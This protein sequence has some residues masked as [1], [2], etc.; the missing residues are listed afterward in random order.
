VDTVA[1]IAERKNL[2]CALFWMLAMAAY[3]H[4]A[5]KP[6]PQRFAL[7]FVCMAVG[8]MA[9]PVLVTLPCV[10]LL[11][12]FWPLRRFNLSRGREKAAAKAP[13]PAF[14]SSSPSRLVLEKLP[15]FA[16]SLASGVI[17]LL[18]HESLGLEEVR[19]GLPLRLRIENAFVSYVRY[20]GKALWPDDL[21]VLYF[22][23]G[24]WPGGRAGLSVLAVLLVSGFA[25]W[26]LRRRPW[27]FVGWFWFL[28]VL[29]PTIGLRQVGV[30]SMADRF[31][32]LP[33]IGL[34]IAVVW[35]AADLT[36][37]WRH[38]RAILAV[39]AGVVL[40]GLGACTF[41]Q[42]HHWQNSVALFQ[43][44]VALDPNNFVARGNL[45]AAYA[46]AGQ[47][48]ESREQAEEAIRTNPAFV[49]ARLQLG[50]LAVKERKF[51]DARM[52]YRN[53]LQTRPA[54]LPS[55]RRIGEDLALSQQ[56]SDAANQYA[57]YL[58]LAPDDLAARG[59]RAVALSLAHRPA[60]AI[61]EYE[62]ILREKPD[63]T[64]I[65]NNLAWLRATHSQTEARNGVEAVRL[66]ERACELSR[67]QQPVY[68]GTLA[69]AYA[70]A[71]RFADAINAAQEAR[72]LALAI[73]Q[74]EVAKANENLLTFY[75]ANKPYRDEKP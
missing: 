70:E 9:K 52:H 35:S 13:A 17:T 65:L 10:L 68:L 53:A 47:L 50:L 19:Y 41:L 55:I 24:Q 39:S 44:V 67:R 2:L 4:H 51:N 57:L 66:A 72:D 1:W 64:E 74:P 61:V 23:P 69:A 30:Q 15:L 45:S 14:S 49:E 18:A 75:R 73:G 46:A 62:A 8:L 59:A 26:Q 31:A 40:A 36:T 42:L 63:W 32:Y 34:F 12:D 27:L 11:L 37:R 21:A 54:A 29:V 38:Q 58:E 28:G 6:S 71:G 56:W 20:L 22:H 5:Q 16:L 3:A 7:V 33:L 25:V 43:R 60:D 48:E